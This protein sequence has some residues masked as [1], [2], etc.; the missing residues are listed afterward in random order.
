MPRITTSVTFACVLLLW[1]GAS[2]VAA[3]PPVACS[4]VTQAELGEVFGGPVGAGTP[5]VVATSCQWVGQQS[6][7][8][9]L[10][11]NQPRGGKS[12]V[13]QFNEGKSRAL[14]GITVEPVT[15]A[16][17][18]AYYVYFTGQNRAGCGLVVRK[19]TAVFEVRVY[20]WD[21]DQA[22]PVAKAIA[23]KIAGKL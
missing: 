3:D 12:P 18:D 4:L 10:T 17:D 20:G 1:S 15:G 21:L 23:A 14:P 2:L 6:K 19:G 22:K 16:G 8:A 13:D 7:R 5:I 11:I 9:T